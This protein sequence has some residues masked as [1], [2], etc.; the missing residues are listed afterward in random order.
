MKPIDSARALRLALRPALFIALALA[1][2]CAS[3]AH[4]GALPQ[5]ESTQAAPAAASPA[6]S[7]LSARAA[8]FEAGVPAQ[9]EV[10][11]ARTGHLLVRPRIDGAD[12]GWFIF[13]T[14]AGI[15]VISTPRLVDFEL[16]HEG[17]LQAIGVGGGESAQLH[18]AR[19]LSLGPIVLSGHP[20]MST[21]L[22]FLEQHLGYAISGVIGYGLLS[23]CVAEI[24]L[25]EA[26]V[27]LHDPTRYELARGA[28]SALDLE[29]RIPA[30]RAR[31]ER[32]EGLFRLDTGASGTLTFHEPAV[33]KWKLLE[34]DD[35][36][37]TSLGGVGGFVPAQRGT[38]E[39]FELGGHRH[40]SV[41]VTLSTSGSGVHAQGRVDGN[42]GGE[43]LRPFVLVLDY[44]TQRIAFQKRA[45]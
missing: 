21:D 17:P 43:L 3:P 14:G 31:F 28:W 24:D 7:A 10:T 45:G 22:S 38:I 42:I 30:V 19:S 11:R 41:V 6:L 20:L 36:Q 5:P 23:R 1:A 8:R 27:A 15:C 18:R 34:L 9:L 25:G 39:W 37:P 29:D 35:L 26:R 33:A 4:Q 44:G 2:G 40:E 12:A 13:D 32:G 16:A